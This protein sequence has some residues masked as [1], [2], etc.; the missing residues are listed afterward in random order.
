MKKIIVLFLSVFMLLS[1]LVGCKIEFPDDLA[2]DTTVYCQSGLESS[3]SNISQ[4]ADFF[5][6]TNSQYCVSQ[7]LYEISSEDSCVSDN[8]EASNDIS[9]VSD[10]SKTQEQLAEEANKHQSG[11]KDSEKDQYSTDKTPDGM[12]KPIEWQK[13]TIDKT[14]IKYCTLSIDC[15]TI[16]DHM[17][18]FNNDKLSVLPNDGIIFKERKVIFYEGE[19]VFDVLNR[20]TKKNR[21]HMEFEM[22]P[23]YNSNYIEGIKNLYEFDC[24]ELS[25]WMYE[26][27]HWYPNY[28]C[29]RYCL[30]DGDVIKWRYTCDLG[31]DLGCEWNG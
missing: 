8:S 29:S 25:G 19:T 27:N 24:G 15:L 30:K 20:E 23:I 13:V 1:V 12:P 7:E 22:T 10:T 21:I 28:G 14:K 18:K 26:V 4:G 6:R 9:S 2:D 3:Q 16:L 17:D 31:R 5:D 11:D